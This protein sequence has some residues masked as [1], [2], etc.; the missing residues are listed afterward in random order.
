MCVKNTLFKRVWAIVDLK[1]VFIRFITEKERSAV[2]VVT[3]TV[4]VEDDCIDET[5]IFQLVAH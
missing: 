1:H 2:A 5:M 4:R 3:G